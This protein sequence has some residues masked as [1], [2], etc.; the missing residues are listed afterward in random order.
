ML[1][2]PDSITVWLP[3]YLH[4][5]SVFH[6]TRN[7][8]SS[9]RPRGERSSNCSCKGRDQTFHPSGSVCVWSSLLFNSVPPC[10]FAFSVSIR[11]V[12]VKEVTALK[13]GIIAD[14]LQGAKVEKGS[15]MQSTHGSFLATKQMAPPGLAAGLF[16]NLVGMSDFQLNLHPPEEHPQDVQEAC[17]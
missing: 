15:Q 7:F 12:L 9:V 4:C 8:F 3:D 1:M 13:H 5:P 11:F 16:G 6:F 10:Q 2:F 14:Y 17:L